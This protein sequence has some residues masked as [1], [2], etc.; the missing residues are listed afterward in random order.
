[1]V[2]ARRHSWMSRCIASRSFPTPSPILAPVW[3]RVNG[4]FGPPLQKVIVA[5]R[6]TRGVA[7]AVVAA[8][9]AGLASA[10]VKPKPAGTVARA[11]AAAARAVYDTFFQLD[12]KLDTPGQTPPTFH[13]G[14]RR[15]TRSMFRCDWTGDSPDYY[16]AAG[17][18]RVTFY[19]YGV[20]AILE[21]G[22]ICNPEGYDYQQTGVSECP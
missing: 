6:V 5:S 21:P 3:Q 19:R 14:C 13:P 11:D 10:A 15:L 17:T 4:P 16:S 22:A 2:S 18:V 9:S 12:P 7:V 20:D 8:V 1:M